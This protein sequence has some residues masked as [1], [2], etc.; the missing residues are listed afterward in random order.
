MK[1]LSQVFQTRGYLSLK[2]VKESENDKQVCA[3]GD[4]LVDMLSV[5]SGART[6][7]RCE[8]YVSRDRHAV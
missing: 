6:G 8:R 4:L 1:L 5:L 7:Y 3:I 2:S